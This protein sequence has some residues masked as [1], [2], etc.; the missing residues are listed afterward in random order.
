MKRAT[1]ETRRSV[2]VSINFFTSPCRSRTRMSFIWG[3]F[4]FLRIFTHCCYCSTTTQQSRR[5]MTC[6]VC[7][8]KKDRMEKREGSKGQWHQWDIA[9]RHQR[10]FFSGMKEHSNIKLFMR[11]A[12]SFNSLWSKIFSGNYSAWSSLSR[13]RRVF[14]SSPLNGWLAQ[15]Y[16]LLICLYFS[17]CQIV[18]MTQIA[19]NTPLPH[20]HRCEFQNW[21]WGF[22]RAHNHH[23]K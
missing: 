17:D 1:A 8:R 18:V 22:F 2:W 14:S 13:R 23:E 15:N 5:R 16:W 4:P 7:T 12:S 21:T 10:N 20:L 9:L 19:K 6:D 11:N 3:S